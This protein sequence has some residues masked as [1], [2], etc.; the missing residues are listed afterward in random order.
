MLD[1]N[2]AIK[3]IRA[4]LKEKTGKPWSVRGGR[5]TGWGWITVSSPPRRRVCHDENPD[6]DWRAY[7][8]TSPCYLERQPKEGEEGY[9]ISDAEAQELANAFGMERPVHCQGLSISPDNRDW[10]VTMVEGD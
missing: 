5:G 10:H 7:P 1:R 3:R 8:S 4:A 9:Y 2:E 6:Y